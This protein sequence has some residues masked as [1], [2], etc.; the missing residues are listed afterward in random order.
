MSRL[1]ILKMVT[2]TKQNQCIYN[3]LVLNRK[4]GRE[5]ERQRETVRDKPRETERDK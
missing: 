2:A 5:R 3:Q 1:E 4:R